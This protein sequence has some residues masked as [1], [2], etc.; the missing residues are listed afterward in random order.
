MEKEAILE[1]IKSGNFT[2]VSYFTYPTGTIY[3]SW[4]F[5]QNDTRIEDKELFEAIEKIFDDVSIKLNKSRDN[6]TA[7]KIEIPNITDPVY[8]STYDCR[9]VVCTKIDIRDGSEI[10]IE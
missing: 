7:V 2:P 8:V 1:A 9:Q 5:D 6:K 10:I 4:L 3:D